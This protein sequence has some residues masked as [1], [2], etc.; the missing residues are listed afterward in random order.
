MSE[1]EDADIGRKRVEFLHS[2]LERYRSETD[3]GTATEIGITDRRYHRVLNAAEKILL[4]FEDDII[5]GEPYPLP[6]LIALDI[7]GFD[8][9]DAG[10]APTRERAERMGW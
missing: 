4:D 2:E 10:W 5:K 7:L 3:A 8:T 9:D 1:I 6:V